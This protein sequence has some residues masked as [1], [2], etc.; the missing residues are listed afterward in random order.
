MTA[1]LPLIALPAAADGIGPRLPGAIYANQNGCFEVLVLITDPPEA[2]RLLRRASAR[3]AVIVRDTL[4]AEGQPFAV[5][6]V[7]TNEDHLVR[8]GRSAYATAA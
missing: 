6:S 8:P 1:P 2:A 4:R 5:G 7:W 3:W